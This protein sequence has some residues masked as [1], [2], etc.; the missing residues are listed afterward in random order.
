[1]WS[2][3]TGD[4]AFSQLCVPVKLC[5][6]SKMSL[7]LLALALLRIFVTTPIKKRQH[8]RKTLGFVLILLHVNKI[9]AGLWFFGLV[10]SGVC[11]M[12]CAVISSAYVTQA[13]HNLELLLIKNNFCSVFLCLFPLHIILVFQGYPK[14]SFLQF[15]FSFFLFFL[16]WQQEGTCHAIHVEVRVCCYGGCQGFSLECLGKSKY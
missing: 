10:V 4:T 1:M 3:H 12:N 15:F 7:Q 8:S 6:N 11:F 9:L 13:V 16:G 14:S 2:Y 5:F